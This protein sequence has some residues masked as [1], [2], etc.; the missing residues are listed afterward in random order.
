ME[1]SSTVSEA[2]RDHVKR[3]L[4]ELESAYPELI[5]PD[6][7]TQRVGAPLSGRLAKV[8]HKTPRQ[9]LQ[10]VFSMSELEDWANRCQK[11]LPKVEFSYVCELKID[12]LNVTLWYEEGHLVRA[13]TRGDGI[14]GE[15]ITHTVRTIPTIPLILP[16]PWSLEVSGEIFM[17]FSSFE[18]IKSE[19][20]A[21]P[22]NAAAGTVRQLDPKV[23]ANRNLSVFFYTHHASD[24]PPTQAEVLSF[25]QTL[26]LPVEPH[27]K[28][29]SS[30]SEVKTFINHWSKNR[31]DLLYPTD[32]IVVKVN[33]KEL[34]HRLG[35]TAKNPR[36][37]VAYKFP[38]QQST[39][40]ILDITLQVGRTGA[41]TPV[42]EL[43]PTLVAGSTISRATLH[44]EDEIKRK[45]VRIG[46]TVVIQKAGD[47][48]PEVVEVLKDLRSGNEKPYRF[49]TDCPACTTWL[50]RE[51]GEVAWRC[52][53]RSCAGKHIEALGHFV[54]RKA[55]DIDALGPKILQ[56]L[57]EK[58]LIS[59]PADIFTLTFDELMSLELFD[60]KRS[61]N[62]ISTIAS[63]K[64]VKLSSLIFALGIR[65]VGEKTARDIAK[66]LQ[67]HLMSNPMQKV[68][69]P[70]DLLSI[71]SAPKTIVQLDTI[72]GIGPKVTESIREWRE[73]PSHI[74]FM[75]KLTMAGIQLLK[76]DFATISD[77]HCTGK[78]FVITGSFQ[79]WSRD[80][81][82]KIVL[83][84]GGKVSASV[85]PKTSVLLCG[86]DPGSKLKKAQE[87]G[88]Q[89]VHEE[90]LSSWL[91][92]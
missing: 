13:I 57:V 54:S 72:E 51:E 42:A 85:T 11:T 52:P 17:S 58:Q 3:E 5:T 71:L 88:V 80:E 61:Q 87:L 84:R 76:E 20:F 62:L 56:Q 43:K 1:N 66:E 46:D 16:E 9:S 70:N 78:T 47:V 83:A 89:I 64:C 92:S 26:A 22:R 90:T 74:H 39:S 14:Q 15:D 68:K 79:N 25:F 48:I 91:I 35:S 24:S 41:I 75:S 8:S 29:C 19:G 55:F 73:Q 34:Q 63:S 6:S 36:W 38:A 23:A 10:D 82:K 44:N 4:E 40:Q 27:W 49:P 31:Q 32:G 86:D 18:K 50:V 37:A 77:I 2:A 30:L 65:H 81:L 7:P 60:I 67:E 33:S 21:N 59:D 12:G 28:R 53:N 69:T 45:D